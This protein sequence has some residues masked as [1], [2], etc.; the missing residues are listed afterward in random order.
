M[1][2][3][4]RIRAVEPQDSTALEGLFDTLGYPASPATIRGR[5]IRLRS[6]SSYAAWVATQVGSVVGFAAGHLLRPV[7]EDRPAAQLIAL[8]TAPDHERTGAGT[9][10]CRE[11]ETWARTNGARR[12]LVNSGEQRL[13]NHVFYEG[14]RLRPDRDPS[15]EGARRQGQREPWCR[16]AALRQ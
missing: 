14:P 2:T 11:V 15:H 16:C 10:L 1:R 4:T 6:D 3:S 13:E 12:V 5:L 9:A 8:V 7:Q